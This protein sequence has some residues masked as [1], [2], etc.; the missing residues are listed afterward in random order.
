MRRFAG[1]PSSPDVSGA[2]LDQR[3]EP[4]LN[5]PA[6]VVVVLVVLGL[7]HFVR[8]YVL[9]EDADRILVW[10]LAFVPAR[11]DTTV[12]SDGVLPGGWGADL[13]TFFTYAL[14]HADI[15][16]LGFNAVWLL[17][18][19]SPVARRFGAGRFQLLLAVSIACGALAYLAAHAG[20]IAPMVGASAGI[21]GMMG[22]AARF[23]FEPGGSLDMWHGNREHADHVPAAPLL[24]AFRNPRVVAFVGVWFALNLLFGLGSLSIAGASNQAVAWEAHLGGFLAGLLLF[25]SFDPVPRVPIANDRPTFH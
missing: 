18:F 9:S 3:R 1:A 19:A 14:V 24:A 20:E 22:A 25:S 15:T 2:R 5:V 17:A 21:S 11:Y 12:F 7:V 13:W 10:S 16:H 23:V 6:V 4:I 8:E